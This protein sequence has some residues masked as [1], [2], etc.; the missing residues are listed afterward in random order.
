MT[1]KG[2][3]PDRIKTVAS[4]FADGGPGAFNLET[5]AG[6][7]FRFIA[8]DMRDGGPL[9]GMDVWEWILWI[10]PLNARARDMAAWAHEIAIQ[11]LDA[12]GGA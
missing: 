1:Y 4:A 2:K 7:L 9:V 3:Y 8:K 11:C 12:S 10:D 5:N 6:A